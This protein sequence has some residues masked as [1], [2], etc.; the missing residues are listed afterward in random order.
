MQ[1]RARL[2]QK[3]IYRAFASSKRDNNTLITVMGSAVSPGMTN[4]ETL[5]MP[6]P[7]DLPI[8]YNQCPIIELNYVIVVTLVIPG[9]IDL[10]IELPLVLT[11][12]ELPFDY[13]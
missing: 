5:S 3:L 13:T 9:S 10:H 7:N 1:L 6:I 8:L 12:Q 2:K 4:N 11:N